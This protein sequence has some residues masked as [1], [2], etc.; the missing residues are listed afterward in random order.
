MISTSNGFIP[1]V[2]KTY[3]KCS[4]VFAQKR[5][6]LILKFDIDIGPES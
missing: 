1:S 5:I 6:F 2:F 3:E 4:D